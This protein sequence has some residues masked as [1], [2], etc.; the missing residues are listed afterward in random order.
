MQTLVYSWRPKAS[1][2]V[3]WG[4]IL[5]QLMRKTYTMKRTWKV[6]L[7][8]QCVFAREAHVLTGNWH[9]R[10]KVQHMIKRRRTMVGRDVRNE[11][12]TNTALT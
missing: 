9:F 3:P 5:G 10:S 1:Y 8:Q 11:R 12:F 6:D 4:E 7:S 2:E